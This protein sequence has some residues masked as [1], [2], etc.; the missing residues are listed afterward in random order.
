[1]KKILFNGIPMATLL[2][3]MVITTLFSSCNSKDDEQMI[4]QQ[5]VELKITA[6]IVAT[7]AVNA[8]WSTGDKIGVFAM[9]GGTAEYSNVLYT[10]A[11]GDGNFT[12]EEGKSIMLPYDGSSRTIAAY[13]PY[14]NGITNGEYKIDV[15]D[16][17]YQEAI[18]LLVATPVNNVSKKSPIAALDFAHKLVKVELTLKPGEGITASQLAYLKVTISNQYTEGTC[19]V[20]NNGNVVA[21]GNNNNTV[22][23]QTSADGTTS[24][25]ILLPAA[26]TE[27]MILT[28]DV[29]G[30]GTYTWE[31]NSAAKSKSFGAGNKYKYDIS[32]NK[33]SLTVNSTIEDWNDG[34]GGENGN[35]L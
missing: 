14:T 1:M 29:P 24:E 19:D 27:N 12:A 21:S 6:G 4:D 30:A 10:T 31:V 16:Q 26:T 18:D 2:C 35:A 28:F 23:F 7:R 5:P 11:N 32:I 8:S 9:D 17:Q 34:N 25:A 15:S 20:I 33:T 22:T 13:Y 3:A